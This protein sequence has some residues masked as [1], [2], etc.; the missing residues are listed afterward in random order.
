MPETLEGKRIIT[1]DI[2]GMIAGAKYRGEF[3]DRMKGVMKEVSEDKSI[4]LFID[5]IHTII[6]AG[7]AEGA[8]DA[9]NIIKP[10][11][12]RGDMQVIGA[13][14]ISEYR[15]HIEKDAAL[16]RRFQS[17]SVGEPTPEEAV[18]ILRGLRD[19]YD[20]SGIH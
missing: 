12:A 2:P 20:R 19:K 11:L 7:A 16:E 15:A 3:E 6:G 9:A 10:A 4:I 17:V 13:T 5:E 1:L 14:T 18:L 8:V